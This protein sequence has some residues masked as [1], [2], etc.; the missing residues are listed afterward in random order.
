MSTARSEQ[1]LVLI[2]SAIDIK[3]SEIKYFTA[4]QG[5]SKDAV[6]ALTTEDNIARLIDEIAYLE[7]LKEGEVVV[8]SGKT[9]KGFSDLATAMTYLEAESIAEG[10]AAPKKILVV[11][12]NSKAALE[13]LMEE[14]EGGHA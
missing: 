12:P 13:K 8:L 9:W 5:F 10:K 14:E 7:A 11:G 1:E 4:L 2:Q 6:D 3:R